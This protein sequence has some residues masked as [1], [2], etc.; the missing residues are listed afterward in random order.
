MGELC[1]PLQREM[2]NT[3]MNQTSEELQQLT[4]EVVEF[5]KSSKSLGAS[6]FAQVYG[7]ACQRA[8]IKKHQKLAEV[9]LQE[10][11]NPELIAARKIKRNE[12]V[13]KKRTSKLRKEMESLKAEKRR[14]VLKELD[15]L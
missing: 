10:A 5:L 14:K 7:E 8:S 12:K 9:N 13:A 6:R 2:N 4:K 11:N 1:G 15:D 3:D